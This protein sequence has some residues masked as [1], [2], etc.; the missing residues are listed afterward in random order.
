[1]RW[2]AAARFILPMT[3][4]VAGFAAASGAASAPHPRSP[5]VT[6]LFRQAAVKVRANPD[7]SR[8]MV[9]EA[10]GV[11]AGK[12]IVKNAS[13]IARWRFVFDNRDSRFASVTIDYRRSSGFGP[14]VG[15]TSPFLEDVEIKKPPKMTLGRAVTL[16]EG[17][18]HRSGFF[19]VTLRSPLGPTTTPPLYI[20]GLAGGRFAAVNTK[21]GSVTPLG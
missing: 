6:R 13:Q 7:F 19:D 20:F 18:G 1:M 3:L 15:H 12:G 21:T 9:L 5:D 17:A 8:A 11:P 10:D 14:P 4:A 2:K 16:L